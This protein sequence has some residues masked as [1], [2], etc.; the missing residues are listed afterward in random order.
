M[1]STQRI[2]LFTRYPQPGKVKTRLIPHVGPAAA[3]VLHTKLTELT[4]RTV[5]PLC[6]QSEAELD[7]YC[8]GGSEPDARAW[9]GEGSWL[10]HEQQG[11]SLGARMLQAFTEAWQSGAGRVIVIGSD[12]PDLTTALLR[13]AFILLTEHDL[14]LG[15]AVDGGYYLLGLRAESKAQSSL[16]VGI[17]WGTDRV[18]QQTLSKA[19]R[20]ELSY[21]LLPDLH[22]IDRP[23]DLAHLDH[24][25]CLQ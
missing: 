11:E 18:L 12:C 10:F 19:V 21:A 6:Q 3:A 14:V 24:H 8:C 1:S 15:P 7:I 22:D 17:D 23:E 9:L 16:F 4:L 13:R 25:P 5:Q 2:L 20:A